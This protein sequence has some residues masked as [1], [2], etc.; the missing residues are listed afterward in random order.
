M[1]KQVDATQGFIPLHHLAFCFVP[2]ARDIY[3]ESVQTV[4]TVRDFTQVFDAYAQFEKNLISAKMESMEESGPTEDGEIS[5]SVI[6]PHF[7]Y[8]ARALWIRKHFD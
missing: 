2:Q 3:E 6:F 8:G 1:G 7:W 4:I 5:T